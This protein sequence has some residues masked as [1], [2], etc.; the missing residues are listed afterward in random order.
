MCSY[1]ACNARLEC[2]P[3]SLDVLIFQK[4]PRN[5]IPDSRKRRG[6]QEGEEL[7]KK[8]PC[9]LNKLHLQATWGPP[10]ANFRPSRQGL[11]VGWEWLE[12]AGLSGLRSECEKLSM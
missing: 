4:K 3:M 1:G 8:A 6:R 12:W 5:Q 10:S 9:G 2:E 7:F 11:K